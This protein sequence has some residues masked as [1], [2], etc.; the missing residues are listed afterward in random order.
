MYVP[1]GTGFVG[2]GV[3]KAASSVV[4]SKTVAY[5]HDCIGPAESLF[6][7]NLSPS[8]TFLIFSPSNNKK[9]LLELGSS[10]NI[11]L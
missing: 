7:I 9:A 5:T 2:A 8:S 10:K 4:F 3:I 1:P 11:L 6:T